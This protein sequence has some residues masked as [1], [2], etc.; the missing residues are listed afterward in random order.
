MQEMNQR[1]VSNPFA[2]LFLF[3]IEFVI[4]SSLRSLPAPPYLA[5]QEAM[6]VTQAQV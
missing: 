4:E 2:A 1:A 5:S 6:G 3:A